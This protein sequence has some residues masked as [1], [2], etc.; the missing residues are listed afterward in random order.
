MPREECKNVVI[1][2][3][4]AIAIFAGFILLGIIAVFGNLIIIISV[5]RNPLKKLH[6]PFNYFLVNLSVCDFVTGAVATFNC[7]LHLQ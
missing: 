7:I 5:I 1:Q 2:S 6:T 4:A 3:S